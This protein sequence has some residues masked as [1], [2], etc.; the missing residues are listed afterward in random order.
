MAVVG[1]DS[2]PSASSVTKLYR[3]GY[4]VTFSAGDCIVRKEEA[5]GNPV[6]RTI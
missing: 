2:S 4:D 1:I 3:D 6:R 5:E